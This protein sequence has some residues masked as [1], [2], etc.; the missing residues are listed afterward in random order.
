VTAKCKNNAA[1]R[2]PFYFFLDKGDFSG[3]KR[4]K[5]TLITFGKPKGPSQELD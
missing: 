3:N 5:N 2:Q 4:W 1:K